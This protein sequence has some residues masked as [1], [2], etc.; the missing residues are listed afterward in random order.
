MAKRIV[1]TVS[2]DLNFDQRMH[3]IC[4]SLQ[5]AGYEVLL[6][7]RA[8]P[9]SPPLIQRD[10]AQKRLKLIFTSGILFYKELNVRLF[11][12]LMRCKMD[13]VCS[14]DLDTL[15]A[16]C[17]ATLLRGK[18]RVFDAH[19]YFTEVPEV[20]NRPLVK[21][22]W[23]LIAGFCLPFYQHAY[24]V[25]PSLAAI[26]RKKY[27]TDFGVVRNLPKARAPRSGATNT[28]KVL[29][30]Q[31][32]L[33]EG[34]GIEAC[35]EAMKELT[36]CELWLVGDG[37][38]SARLRHQAQNSPAANRIKFFGRVDPE[39]LPEI[40]R[41]A[42]LGINILDNKGL[43]YYY[44]LANKFFDYVQDGVPVVCADFPEYQS[45]NAEHEVAVLVPASRTQ[46]G[47][48][49]RFVQSEDVVNAIKPLLTDPDLYDKL[50][51]N[52]MK[53]R[54]E[55]TWEKEEERLLGIWEKVF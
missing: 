50:T 45:L 30:Y 7:G 5:K 27:N 22:A 41:K 21:T 14:I 37:D 36:E 19:E 46:K 16:G 3:R 52:C 42:W 11:F 6:V 32:A 13:A 49:D 10:F 18:K 39:N 17:F 31:G 2:N 26:F 4:N 25:G 54:E 40:T 33:N 43:S 34:R 24:T 29:L 20:V 35:I 9:H 15:P 23:A 53:A 55:W 47:T 38:L 48:K 8:L 1:C 28:N 51:K 44:S 12:Y